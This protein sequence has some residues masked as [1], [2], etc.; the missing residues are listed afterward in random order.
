MAANAITKFIAALQ[1]LVR[2]GLSKQAAEQF[3]KNEF[4]EISKFLQKRIDDVYKNPKGEGIESI[5]IKDEV[6]DDT[7]IKLPIDDTGQP[8]N[9]NNPLKEYGKP[10]KSKKMTDV[11]EAIDNASPGFA[12]DRKYDA[13]LVADDLAEKRFG[14]EFYDLDEIDQMELYDEAYQGLSKQRFKQQQNLE[15]QFNKDVEEAGGMEAFLN[16]NPI[17]EKPTFRLNKERFKKD[18]NV[19]DEEVEKI[20]LLSPEDQQKK[21]KEYIDKDFKERIELSDYDVTDLEPNAEGGIVGY[22][23]GGMVDVEPSLSDIGHGSDAL[24]ARTRLISPGAQ[25]TTSTG[26]N[27]LLAEDNDNIRVPFSKGKAVAKGLD[28]LMDLFKPKP[29]VIF[30]EKRFREGPIDLDFLE[31][32]DKKDLEPFIRSRDTMGPGG[33][34]MYDDF[35]DMPSGLQAAE[36][37]SRI[38][39]PRN[40]INY[41]AAEMFIGKKLKGNESVDELIEMLI[42]KKAEGGRIG[43]AK[44][45]GVDLLRRGFLKTMGAAG[46]GIAALKSGL[47]GLGGKQATKE[48]AKEIITTPAAAGK[49]AWFDALVTRVVNE[50][51]DV[52]KKFATKDREI[53]HATKVDDDAMVTVYRDLDDGTVRVDIDDATTNVMG[54]Q[55]DSVVSLE[56]KGGQ[57]EEGVKG[58]TPVEFEAR[59][60]DYRNYMDGPDDYTTE[61][62]DNVVTDTKDLTADLTKVKMYAKGQKKP[63]IKEMMIQRDRAK[64]LKQAEENPAEY[65]ADRGPDIDTKD[66]DYAS[67]GI[68]RMI[69]E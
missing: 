45:K 55:G 29:K 67:G 11:E 40:T 47:L 64:T 13:Q 28:Y 46:A 59:E 3:A 65:A 6:F 17:S 56:V 2:Q 5:K 32:I 18:F 66:Y 36:L 39:G 41:E 19:T 50:G 1:S 27:Y 8:F 52:T 60:A 16:A 33:Y 68:A 31:N 54:E 48:V 14:K 9:P 61:T 7:V 62:I 10:K 37:I 35:A 26:L 25:G 43:F 58:K 44:G 4:G 53:V 20:S 30:D 63:T 51:E 69:G 15:K 21:V 22:Y 34:G 42:E 23:T 24:M 57:L 38:K 49:P 12:D